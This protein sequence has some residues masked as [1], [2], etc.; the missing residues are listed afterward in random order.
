MSVL[1]G[2]CTIVYYRTSQKTVSV[3]TPVARN[4]SN[5]H[6]ACFPLPAPKL[7]STPPSLS[8]KVLKNKWPHP[9]TL[10]LLHLY[11]IIY[12]FLSRIFKIE[13]SIQFLSC[14]HRLSFKS[15]LRTD[16]VARHLDFSF[17]TLLC[18]A[19]LSRFRPYISS[20]RWPRNQNI[21]HITVIIKSE[22]KEGKII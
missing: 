1:I 12:L 13:C 16:F 3:L 7:T 5:C 11:L 9:T 17:C 21:C 19:V 10:V 4:T 18:C 2:V 8:H 15:I 6:F 20:I 14:F 22:S